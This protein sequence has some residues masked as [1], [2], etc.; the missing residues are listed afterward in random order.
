MLKKYHSENVSVS[1]TETGIIKLVFSIITGRNNTL[2]NIQMSFL[3][4]SFTIGWQKKKKKSK[5]YCFFH[6][7]FVVMKNPKCYFLL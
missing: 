2:G 5:L 6:Y 1:S 3:H 7:L 4:W